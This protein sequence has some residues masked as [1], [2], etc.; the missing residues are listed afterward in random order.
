M[1]FRGRGPLCYPRAVANAP[2]LDDLMARQKA[3]TDLAATMLEETDIERIQAI[4]AELQSQAAELQAMAEQFAAT[5]G[6]QAAANFTEVVLTAAQRARILETTGVT[7]ETLKLPD[8]AGVAARSMPH[9]D[10]RII[11]YYAL[12]EAE[13]IKVAA[14]ADRM[15]KD[16][17]RESLAAIE[18]QG[19]PAVLEELEKL[20][21]DPAFVGG[22]VQKLDE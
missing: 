20:K 17:L 12:R 13:R 16:Q 1:T 11:E 7:L 14:E 21:R 9:T 8:P 22:L 2:S 10:P 6:S 3:M 4:A 18:A 19:T 15:I 5:A